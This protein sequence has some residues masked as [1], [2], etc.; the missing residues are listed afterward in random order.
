MENHWITCTLHLQKLFSYG[1]PYH[2]THGAQFLC[3][4]S[5]DVCNSADFESADSSKQVIGH[6]G[7]EK[8]SFNRKQP[9]AESVSGLTHWI[10]CQPTSPNGS[11]NAFQHIQL[12]KWHIRTIIWA[13]YSWCTYASHFGAHLHPS[14]SFSCCFWVSQYT[15]GY[16]CLLRSALVSLS[17]SQCSPCQQSNQI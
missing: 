14:S 8:L 4:W 12:A 3:W 10:H 2:E 1:N 7:K 17:V 11:V 15:S 16:W 5:E 6:T 13:N 9:L